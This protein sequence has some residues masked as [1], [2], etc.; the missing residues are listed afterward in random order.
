MYVRN[1]RPLVLSRRRRRHRVVEI[2]D[3]LGSPVGVDIG[4]VAAVGQD[5]DTQGFFTATVPRT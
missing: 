1:S 5:C 4:W 2:Q 3:D